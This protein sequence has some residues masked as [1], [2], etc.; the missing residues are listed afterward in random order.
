LGVLLIEAFIG[1]SLEFGFVNC[2]LTI[3]CNT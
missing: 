1:K 3:S 2:E